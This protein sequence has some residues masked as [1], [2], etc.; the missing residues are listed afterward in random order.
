[1]REVCLCSG[2]QNDAMQLL[3]PDSDK[4]LG[5]PRRLVIVQK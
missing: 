1:V 2:M 4:R 5:E 3:A